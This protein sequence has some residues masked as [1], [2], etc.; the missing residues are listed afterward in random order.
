MVGYY[1]LLSAAAEFQYIPTCDQYN[2]TTTGDHEGRTM[3][4]LAIMIIKRMV[5]EAIDLE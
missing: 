2:F 3:L 5:K 1:F 4:E